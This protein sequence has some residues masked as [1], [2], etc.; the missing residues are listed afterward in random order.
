MYNEIHSTSLLKWYAKPKT[1]NKKSS[2]FP[3]KQKHSTTT[4]Q[5]EAVH[6]V[7]ICPN[8]QQAIA[9]YEDTITLPDHDINS[10]KSTTAL[11]RYMGFR[12]SYR[13][14]IQKVPMKHLLP[15]NY[16]PDENLNDN[17]ISTNT[18]ATTDDDSKELT[19]NQWNTNL[20]SLYLKSLQNNQ[21]EFKK[22]TTNDT[23]AINH[24]LK[25]EEQ[26]LQI[27]ASS[28]L[29]R[30]QQPQSKNDALNDDTDI[31]DESQANN[32]NPVTS[33]DNLASATTVAATKKENAKQEDRPVTTVTKL[34]AGDV[35]EYWYVTTHITV[36][37]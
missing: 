3:K 30:E 29:E 35:I 23:I 28:V 25:V 2:S 5:Y 11:V 36:H 32:D 24:K 7:Y 21:Q 10:S 8:A 6:P 19:T 9:G 20:M 15:Y 37:E 14:K 4:N 16:N 17:D 27:I 1:K 22:S 12:V 26:L 33:T 18:N 13:D 34:R 31:D